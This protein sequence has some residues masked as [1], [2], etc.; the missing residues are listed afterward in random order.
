MLISI[1][2]THNDSSYIGTQHPNL[3]VTSGAT[4]TVYLRGTSAGQYK[5]PDNTKCTLKML[6]MAVRTGLVGQASRSV[7]VAGTVDCG[8]VTA[9]IGSTVLFE[10][11]IQESTLPNT[12][13]ADELVSPFMNQNGSTGIG[14]GVIVPSGSTF[15]IKVT[16]AQNTNTIWTCTVF[17]K[18][19]TTA[20][21]Q[22]GTTLTATTTADQI[23]L[24]YTPASDWTIMSIYVDA[25]VPAQLAGQAT[26]QLDGQQIIE[27]P[28]LGSGESTSNMFDID[29][30]CGIGTGS[31]NIPLWGI[32]LYPG[33]SIGFTPIPFIGDKST[34]TL[35]IAGTES[36]LGTGTTGP[37]SWAY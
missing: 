28:Y 2:R 21:I 3:D 23:I 35:L 9:N 33:E 24:T 1:S 36:S 13:G 6:S 22:G 27:T 37:T 4:E 34:W 12:A 32:E 29:S 11:R 20:D 26:M 18:R 16:P 5:V 19:G 30:Y 14:H 17:G 25:E 10:R 15:T 8:K 7:E 31:L